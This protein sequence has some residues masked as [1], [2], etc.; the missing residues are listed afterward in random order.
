MSAEAVRAL[1]V[2]RLDDG[3]GTEADDV[4][5]AEEPLEVRVNGVPFAVIMRTPGQDV[6]LAAGFLLAEDV[7]RVPGEIATIERCD[8][9]EAEAL[10][11]VLNVTVTG[12]AAERVA[13]RLGERRQIITTAACGLCGR[14]TIESIRARVSS[15]GGHWTVPAAVVSS[16]P[17]ALLVAQAAFAR[18]GGIHA[19]ALC[20]LQGRVRL[21]AE[22]VGR[23]NALD[24]IVGRALLEGLVPLD[25]TLLVVSGRS[26]YELVQ[27]AL[28][29]GVPLVA[30]VSAPSSLAVDLARE[31]G[32]TLCGFVRGG[33][34]NVY[35]H[36][37]RITRLG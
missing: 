12:R 15:V 5:A 26:S 2:L 19:S 3:V 9:V 14:R 18:T 4:V 33:S 16:L 29:A 30:A 28:L 20:D 27:K 1:G 36:P 10:G 23:H 37:Q 32:I 7:V 17:E 31:S 8:D 35:T 21:A 6:A 13:D 25:D 22:D 24:K 34:M 11:N